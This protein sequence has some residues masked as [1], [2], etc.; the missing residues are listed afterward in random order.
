M[1]FS[2]LLLVMAVAVSGFASADDVVFHSDVTLARI[3]AQVLDRDNRPIRYLSQHD[4][5]LIEN[6]KVQ[7]IRG[8]A[9]ENMPLDILFLLDVSGSMRPH[10]ERIADASHEALSVL[11]PN[12]RMGI[13]VFDR[14]TRVRLPFTS[15]RAGVERGFDR[16]LRDESFNGGTDITRGM[17]DAA[18]YMRR[19]ARPNA[20]R[21]IIILTDDETEFDRDDAGVERALARAN[22]IMCALIAPNAMA[23]YGGRRGGGHRGT[24]GSGGG[25]GGLGGIILGRGGYGYPGGGYPGGGGRMGYPHTQSAGTSEIARASGGDSMPVDSA[26]ALRDTLERLRQRYT[27]YFNLPDGVQPGQ[28]Q[29]VQVELARDASARY[30]GAEVRYRR[31]SLASGGNNGNAAPIHVT[32][33]PLGPGAGDSG[34]PTDASNQTPTLPHHVAVNEDGSSMDGPSITPIPARARTQ[35][36]AP[37]PA[38]QP[39]AAPASPDQ[40]WRRVDDPGTEGSDAG[41]ITPVVGGKPVA[42]APAAKKTDS[43]S[44]PPAATTPPAAHGWPRINQS[45]NNQ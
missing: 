42:P 14:R 4:F 9:A 24:W 36:A 3:D 12:D 15:D 25:I 27:L 2:A 11:G 31:V 1:R 16:L 41:P 21:A 32:R 26:Y 43:T 37:A 7:P 28:E 34:S 44:T 18:E 35:A 13:M 23:Q 20:R 17:L 33:V 30:P 29:N 8:F 45:Q 6:G 10:V 38:Q 39:A 5:V 40:G 19:N 22:T